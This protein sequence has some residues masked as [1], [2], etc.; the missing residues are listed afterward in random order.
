MA[1]KIV[2]HNETLRTEHTQPF[3]DNYEVILSARRHS[4]DLVHA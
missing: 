3:I 4:D 1:L 2:E